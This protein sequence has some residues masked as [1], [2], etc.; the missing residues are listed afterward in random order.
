MCR[1]GQTLDLLF[2]GIHSYFLT[3]SVNSINTPFHPQIKVPIKFTTKSGKEKQPSAASPSQFLTMIII[4]I[5]G[6][7][8]AWKSLT[9]TIA[10]A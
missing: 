1:I 3:E 10:I 9:C 8:I 7:F 5:V 6:D 4:L 2:D